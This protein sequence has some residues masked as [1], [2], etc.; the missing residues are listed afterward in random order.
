MRR[1][2]SGEQDVFAIAGR[3]EQYA[4]LEEAHRVLR[5]HRTDHDIVHQRF[6]RRR[7][8]Q[9]LGAQV[10]ADQPDGRL[11]QDVVMRQDAE[12]FEALALEAAADKPGDF[13]N[14][15]LLHLVDDDAD[16]FDALLFKQRLVQSHL[17]NRLADAAAAKQ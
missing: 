12:Q 3:N 9:Q 14:F 7:R 2:A 1:R 5:A 15:L 6:K 17:I 13:G 8:V 10:F 11:G 4:A 16:D